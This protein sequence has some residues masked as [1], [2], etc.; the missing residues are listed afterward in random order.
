MVALDTTG[1]KIF[2]LMATLYA[3]AGLSRQAERSVSAAHYPAISLVIQQSLDLCEN[4]FDAA[5]TMLRTRDMQAS[6]NMVEL[7][8]AS[9]VALTVP[10]TDPAAA[11]VALRALHEAA[12]A[13]W[14]SLGSFLTGAEA[15]SAAAFASSHGTLVSKFG[16][17]N[18]SPEIA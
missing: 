10:S 18:G 1:K 14:T 4:A 7:T 8:S 11:K 12:Q 17:S 13:A 9:P 16:V 2:A 5:L 3:G 15:I 6:L